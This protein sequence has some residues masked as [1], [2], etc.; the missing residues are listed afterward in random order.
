[1]DEGG[2]MPFPY[3]PAFLLLV[4]PFGLLSFPLGLIAWSLAG[5]ILYLA[6]ARQLTPNGALLAAAFPPVFA[7]AALG[8]NGF[9]MAALFL[10]GLALLERRPFLAG[11][12]LGCLILKPQLA[13]MLPVAMLAGRH[14]QVIGGAIFSSIFVMAAGFLIFGPAATAAWLD[15]LP[16]YATIARDGLVGWHKFVSIYA[17]ARQA[18]VPELAAF[19]I[20]IAIALLAA[21]AVW[22][23]WRTAAGWPAKAAILVA[24]TMLAS[25]YLYVYDA[26]IL[27]PAFAF[28]IGRRAPVALVAIAWLL[29]IATMIQ[30]A[31]GAW[32]VNIG[33]LSAL[34]LLALVWRAEMSRK[35]DMVGN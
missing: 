18:G 34:I 12:V 6:V 24:A 2:E 23:V 1:F 31:S 3:P 5:Y 25:P 27:I 21:V 20:H 7:T 28:L 29:P 4:M 16:L 35:A 15:Q 22:R 8:Q 26:L 32:P 10:G 14:W 33:P 11:A 19:T 17:A 13:L 9:V 30:V